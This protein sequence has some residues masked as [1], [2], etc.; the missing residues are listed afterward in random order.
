[1]NI[2]DLTIGQAKEL[3]DLFGNQVSISQPASEF[4]GKTVLIRSRDSG[5]HFGE[6]LSES[7]NSVVLKNS[8]RMDRFY[9]SGNEDSLSG[10]ARNGI[11]SEK[12]RISGELPLIQINNHCEII[13]ISGEAA[14]SIACAPVFTK[15]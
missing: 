14:T 7:D 13:P 10:V 4:I 9:I 12:G 1:M 8:R 6:L 3:T 5:V 2:N 15:G 11:I